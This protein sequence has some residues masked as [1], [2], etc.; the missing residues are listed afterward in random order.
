MQLN[1]IF[2]TR[3]TTPKIKLITQTYYSEVIHME[4]NYFCLLSNCL[5]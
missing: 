3:N 5:H 4:F 2:D 1:T